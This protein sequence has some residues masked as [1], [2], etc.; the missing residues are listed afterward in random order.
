MPHGILA[1]VF[2]PLHCETVDDGTAEK[3]RE[4]ER[5]REKCCTLARGACDAPRA[6]G[7]EV[8]G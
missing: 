6:S 7:R 1:R 3:E 4:R 8:T 2:V 5:E